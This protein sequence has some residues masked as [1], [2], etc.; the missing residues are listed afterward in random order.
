MDDNITESEVIDEKFPFS[1]REVDDVIEE[2][3]VSWLNSSEALDPRIKKQILERLSGLR[4]KFQVLMVEV[5]KKIFRNFVLDLETEE[6]T[7][8]YLRTQMP[9]MSNKERLEVLKT[10]SAINEDRLKRLETQL[11]GFDFLNTT[12]TALDTLSEIKA[13]EDIISEVKKLEPSRRAKLLLA[14]NEIIKE[15]NNLEDSK[16][17]GTT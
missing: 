7:R 2:H 1:F 3:L 17:D 6:M 16:S 13:S 11:T 15:I 14:A 8:Q 5:Q 12:F 10:V 9:F 4:T